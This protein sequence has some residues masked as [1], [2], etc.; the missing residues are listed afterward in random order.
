MNLKNQ[1]HS[2][3]FIIVKKIAVITPIVHLKGIYDLLLTKGDVFLLEKGNKNQVKKLLLEKDINVIVCNPNHQNYKIDE[4]LLNGTQVNIINSCSTGLNHIDLEYCKKNNIKIQCHKNDYELINQ[5]PSTSELAFGLMLSLLR[6]IPECNNHVSGYYWDYT[7]FMGRQVKDLKI[8]I[9]G[10]GRLGKMMEGYCKS[11]G[12]KTFI[13][14]PY[15]NISQTSLEVMFKKCDVISL[16]VHVTD[17]T[18][19][20]INQKLLGLSKKG[21]YLVNTSRGEI[22]NEEDIVQS[23]NNKNLLGYGTDVI[24]D[25]FNDITNSPIIKAMNEGKNIIITPHV[26]GMTIEGQTKA[27]KWSINKL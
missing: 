22:V 17:E 11:F 16:H 5:L 23:L 24:E 25:E 2:K 18:K 19:Y 21:L 8:G 14:D 4:E 12:A 7:Q 27:Y 1:I 15:V 20:M 10:Y 9:I 13:Y 6:N 3:D 26:G